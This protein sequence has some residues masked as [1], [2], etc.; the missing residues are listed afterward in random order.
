[1]R[2]LAA[3]GYRLGLWAGAFWLSSRLTAEVDELQ[4]ALFNKGGK[5]LTVRHRRAG[6]IYILDPTH[7]KTKAWLTRTFQTYREWGIRYYMIDF[8][9]SIAGPILG[10]YL[11]DHYY[12]KDVIP[13]PQAFR[14]GLQ[15]IREA[16]GKDTYLL[17]STGP[18]MHGVGL[19][20]GVRGGSDYGEGRALDGPGKGFFPGTF[21]INKPDY[22][23]SH[24]QAL[25]ALAS[26][27]FLHNRLFFADMGNVLTVDQP[28]GL[29]DARISATIFGLDGG[30]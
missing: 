10:R 7:P 12:R 8:L 29:E 19:L 2:D 16:A 3:R 4:D 21:V 1:M 5:P 13:G 22:W 20:D 28:V 14:E 17:A 23:T 15:V 25:Q 11:P 18:T 24:R 27:F 6:D 9:D 26:N 30:P